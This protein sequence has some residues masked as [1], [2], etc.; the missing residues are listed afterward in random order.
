[1]N[2]QNE[3]AK[4][5]F[6]LTDILMNESECDTIQQFIDA[7]QLAAPK[8]A[9]HYS[10]LDFDPATNQRIS[11]F[12]LPYFQNYLSDF[13]QDVSFSTGSFLSKTP[14]TKNEL[15]MHQDWSYVDETQYRA[16]TCWMPL[17]DTDEHSGTLAFIRGSHRLWCNRRSHSYES[18]RFR[19]D[20]LPENNI[21]IL[22]IK[23]GQIVLFDAGVW[24]GSTPNFKNKLRTAITGLITP[25]AADFCYYHKKDDK[26]AL[27]YKMPAY[28]LETHL[29]Q[30]VKSEIPHSFTLLKEENYQ[31]PSISVADF[32]L[33]SITS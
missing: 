20:E 10:L 5:G 9:I 18:A 31:H 14:Y 12:I 24:H 32:K 13:F 28:G 7:L 8:Q 33:M 3:L 11:N 30:L 19:F 15:A 4:H 29:H 2:F 21:E 1:M 16:I 17:I 22:P 26:T 25:K 6:L 23:K 27:V